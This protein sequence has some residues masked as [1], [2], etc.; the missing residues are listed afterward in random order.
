[1][2]DS[3]RT[4]SASELGDAYRSGLLSPVDVA[5]ELLDTIPQVNVEINAFCVV[6]PDTTMAAARQSAARYAASTPIG[7]LD[8]V[9]V[10]IKDLLLTEGWPTLRLS[11]IHI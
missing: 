7:P 2:Q 11:L 5:A 8:G 1:M 10:S 4:M 6:D 3:V 9:P